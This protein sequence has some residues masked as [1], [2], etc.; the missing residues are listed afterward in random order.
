MVREDAVSKSFAAQALE[1][2][3]LRASVLRSASIAARIGS[4]KLYTV[5]SRAMRVAVK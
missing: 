2:V 1:L 4:G 3:A 5:V